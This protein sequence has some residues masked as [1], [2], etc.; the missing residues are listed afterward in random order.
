VE[1]VVWEGHDAYVDLQAGPATLTLIADRQ[2]EPAAK[3]NVDLVML[4]SDEAQV[5]TRIEKEGYLPLDGMLTQEGDVYLK[6]HNA[7]NAPA[8]T[9]SMA[10]GTEHSPYWVH[11]RN[12]KPKTIAAKPGEST[13]WVEAAV[14]SIR[15]TMG[16]GL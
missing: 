3:R 10:N 1:N 12:W 5:K 7:A 13:D 4:T 8:L 16:S 11:I 6:V 2:P 14:C 9:L 15:S